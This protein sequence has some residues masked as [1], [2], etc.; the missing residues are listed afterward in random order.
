MAGQSNNRYGDR[1][2]DV[3]DPGLVGQFAL[4]QD[5]A[6]AGQTAP[7][8]AT[9]GQLGDVV[10][11]TDGNRWEL[12][13]IIGGLHYWALPIDCFPAGNTEYVLCIEDGVVL[14]KYKLVNNAGSTAGITKTITHG[15]SVANIIKNDLKKISGVCL[16]GNTYTSATYYVW[17]RFG[18]TAF[19]ITTGSSGSFPLAQ[20]ESVLYYTK[21]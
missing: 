19:E 12:I 8:T 1:S 3:N 7:T 6:L 2:V 11:D 15:L 21:T 16:S 5:K 4:K 20:F 10:F 17:T 13:G 9:V 18:T 14:Y